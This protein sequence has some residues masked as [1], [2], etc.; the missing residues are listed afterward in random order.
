MSGERDVG[1]GAAAEE[2]FAPRKAPPGGAREGHEMRT[3]GGVV[4]APVALAARVGRFADPHCNSFLQRLGNDR[5]ALLS[6]RTF[7]TTVLDVA[8]VSHWVGAD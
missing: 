5:C 3:R 7:C 4:R 1:A 6:R 2:I 8:I